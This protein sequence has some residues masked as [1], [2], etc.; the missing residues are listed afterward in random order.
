MAASMV[1][2]QSYEDSIVKEEGLRAL[3]K[4]QRLEHKRMKKGWQ[5]VKIKHN[6]SILVPCDKHGNPTKEGKRKIE[7]ALQN[8]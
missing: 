5:Y 2:T 6:L 1:N 3:E 8:S 4:A 7:I